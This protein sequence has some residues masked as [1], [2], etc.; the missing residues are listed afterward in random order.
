MKNQGNVKGDKW[1]IVEFPAILDH[2][3]EEGKP[4][5]PEYWKIE[6]N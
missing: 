3:P 1:D 6:K 2:G 5:W 4:V